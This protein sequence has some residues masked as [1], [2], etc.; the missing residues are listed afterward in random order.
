MWSLALYNRTQHVVVIMLHITVCILESLSWDHAV[1]HPA[2]EQ[3]SS[4]APERFSTP[5]C[6]E[7][8]R[9]RSQGTHFLSRGGRRRRNLRE[10]DAI[11]Q[12][13]HT[14]YFVVRYL[15]VKQGKFSRQFEPVKH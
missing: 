9:R 3:H 8:T 7:G 15:H 11:H 13:Q 14:V 2:G 1:G 12:I 6:E 5:L 4:F 10:R